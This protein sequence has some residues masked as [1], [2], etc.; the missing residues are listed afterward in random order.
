MWGFPGLC[1]TAP[2]P[3]LTLTVELIDT[4]V[5]SVPP[6]LQCTFSEAVGPVTSNGCVPRST[7]V[8]LGRY[9]SPNFGLCQTGGTAPHTVDP[10]Q[11][12]TLQKTK[13]WSPWKSGHPDT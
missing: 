12:C 9:A 1:L 13:T 3:S 2:G 6:K 8:R 10:A 11:D 4:L 7:S 5:D